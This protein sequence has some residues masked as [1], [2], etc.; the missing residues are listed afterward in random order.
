MSLC[1]IKTTLSSKNIIFILA[2]DIKVGNNYNSIKIKQY[3]R[4]FIMKA[5]TNYLKRVFID[6]LTGMAIGLFSTLIIGTI[7]AQVGNLVGGT[8]GEYLVAISAVA[9]S[10]TGAGIGVGVA[11]KLKASPLVTVSA[12]VAAL[13][14][15]FPNVAL[16]AINIGT[17]GE[18]LGAFL[19]AY[20]AI[21]IG[22]LVS[23]KTKVDIIRVQFSCQN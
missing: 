17:P 14:G 12:V 9:K 16:T 4:C 22:M 7:I 5:I 11:C 2:L 15:A 13:I 3:K 23:G 1:C 20:V 10:A 21:E 6:G 19:A 18:P 8:V